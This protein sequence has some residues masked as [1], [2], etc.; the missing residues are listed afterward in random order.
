MFVETYYDERAAIP[1]ST[2]EPLIPYPELSG[3]A[4]MLWRKYLPVRSQVGNLSRAFYETI[5]HPAVE[6]LARAQKQPKL[7]DRIEVWSRRDPDP[8]LVGITESGGGKARYYSIAR[9]G[10]A[11]LT[12]AQV[13]KRLR[14]QQLMFWLTPVGVILAYLAAT[15]VLAYG[16]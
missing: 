10:D 6:E 3:E 11:A 5:P 15:L 14:V 8:M 13:K 4:L 16:V 2:G 12:L 9:W 7:F 1:A